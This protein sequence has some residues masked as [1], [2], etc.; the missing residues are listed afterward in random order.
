M[1]FCALILKPCNSLNYGFC[2]TLLFCVELCVIYV[3]NVHRNETLGRVG[4]GLGLMGIS[5]WHCNFI[6][7]LKYNQ[8]YILY[9]VLRLRTYCEPMARSM[10]QRPHSLSPTLRLSGSVEHP[11]FFFLV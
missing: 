7:R 3:W 10:L 2:L 1:F 6:F 9:L 4:L 8:N 11:Y 5:E